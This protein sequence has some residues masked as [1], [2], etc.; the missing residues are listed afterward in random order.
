MV[1]SLWRRL[2]R[3]SLG[4]EQA[5]LLHQ[6]IAACGRLPRTAHDAFTAL[7]RKHDRIVVVVDGMIAEEG[8]HVE[9]LARKKEY[10]RLYT[11][12]LLEEDGSPRGKVLH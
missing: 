2:C 12:Q 1:S 8:T 10:S 6:H 7:K 4:V 11:L 5:S 9:L 3:N